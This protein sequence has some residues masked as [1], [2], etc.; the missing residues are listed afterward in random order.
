VKISSMANE[1]RNHSWSISGSHSGNER[2]PYP[3]IAVLQSGDDRARRAGNAIEADILAFGDP[4]SIVHLLKHSGG[5]TRCE[6]PSTPMVA[7]RIY[8]K[9]R[10]GRCP[11]PKAPM[12]TCRAFPTWGWPMGR[13][14]TKQGT[15]ELFS[16]R[17][18][19][20]CTYGGKTVGD[21]PRVKCAAKM[22]PLQAGGIP[23]YSLR[24]RITMSSTYRPSNN[25]APHV[26]GR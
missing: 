14:R 25:L 5:S 15:G 13:T 1:P 3:Q 22:A 23:Q 24:R 7:K 4:E 26:R 11:A 20:C 17:R 2:R 9:R 16:K 10:F 12:D 18:S 6:L 21:C 8:S 19:P